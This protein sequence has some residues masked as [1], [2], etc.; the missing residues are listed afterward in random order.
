MNDQSLEGFKIMIAEDDPINFALLEAFIFELGAECLWVKNGEEA[1]CLLDEDKDIHL[2]LMDINMPVMDGITATQKIREKQI[3]IPVI[4]QTA[5]DRGEKWQECEAAGG[6][7]YLCK[8]IHSEVLR[9]LL[10]K[11]LM[12][13]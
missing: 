2:I 13:A 8:P 4:F 6:N 7:D 5:C 9:E 12:N 11:Y 3:S 10:C 1:L